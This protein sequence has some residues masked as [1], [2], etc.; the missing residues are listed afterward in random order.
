MTSPL[1]GQPE[2]ASHLAGKVLGV[3]SIAVASLALVGGVYI[4]L[5]VLLASISALY[6][7]IELGG[8]IYTFV[9]FLSVLFAIPLIRKYAIRSE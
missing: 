9:I 3:P 4:A 8:P 1:A 5:G 2:R 7:H 6:R